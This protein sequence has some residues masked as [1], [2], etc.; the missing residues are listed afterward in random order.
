MF[1]Q[2]Y[3]F[4]FFK[5]K[6]LFNFR[7]R[8]REGGR[9]GEKDQCVVASRRAPPTR[10][11]A[12]NPGMCPDRESNQR[13]FDSQAGTQSTEPHQPGLN[14]IIFFLYPTLSY[15]LKEITF[16]YKVYKINKNSLFLSLRLSPHLL[17]HPHKHTH[18]HPNLIN[19]A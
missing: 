7:E 16:I 4:L 10:D 15:P 1:E 9:E 2:Y 5:K 13:T 3:I 18:T 12:C 14:N 17:P 19:A 8:G 6:Y 11:P